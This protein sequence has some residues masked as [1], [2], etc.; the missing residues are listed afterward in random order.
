[1]QRF[2]RGLSAALLV[3]LQD[4]RLLGHLTADVVPPA[5]LV[6]CFIST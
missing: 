6:F 3:Y 1:M 5:V 4:V 2:S